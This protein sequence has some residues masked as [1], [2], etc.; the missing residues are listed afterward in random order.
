MFLHACDRFPLH[1]RWLV[2]VLLDIGIHA[3]FISLCRFFF[4]EFED[5]WNQLKS[6]LTVPE[7]NK[8]PYFLLVEYTNSACPTQSVTPSRKFP[9]RDM[10]LQSW[11]QGELPRLYRSTCCPNPWIFVAC[12]QFKLFLHG[13]HIE[14]YYDRMRM[15]EIDILICKY[16]YIHPF[17]SRV[18]KY[19]NT[20]MY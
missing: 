11:N 16:L 5:C 10:T 7:M 1:Y 9:D 17:I 6:T 2:S 3:L 14:I 8:Y 19:I 20:H 4:S 15:N 12:F 18:Y 13:M